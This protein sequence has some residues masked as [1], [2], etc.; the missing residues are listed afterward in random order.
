MKP[1]LKRWSLQLS[2]A[3][4]WMNASMPWAGAVSQPHREREQK[5][6]PGDCLRSQPLYLSIWL[7]LICFLYNKTVILNIV[8]SWLLSHSSGLNVKGLGKPW[9][10][11]W[12]VAWGIPE[13]RLAPEVRA[14]FWGP[15]PLTSGV[16]AV[17]ESW[18][19]TWV[20][21]TRVIVRIDVVSFLYAGL[22]TS[23]APPS[24]RCCSRTKRLTFISTE[25]IMLPRNR[26]VKCSDLGNTG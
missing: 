14:V 10:C 21:G 18:R 11:S 19:Q 16:C 1:Q 24:A 4:W 13:V 2:G 6:S 3:P 23:L 25:W 12:L 20:P 22:R 7:V 17:S 9:I 8:L 5:L 26:K 15:V